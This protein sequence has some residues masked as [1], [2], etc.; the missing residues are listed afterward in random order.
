MSRIIGNRGG[1]WRATVTEHGT[2]VPE[3][4]S[5]ELA[6]HVAGD[7]R[8]Y[9]PTQ[10]PTLRQKWYAGFPVCETRLRVGNGDIVQRIYSVADL[11][12]MTVIE[13][14]N[15]STLPV[16]IAVTR[17]DVFTMRAPADNPPAGIDLPASSIVLPLGHKSTTRIALAHKNPASGRLPED[18]PDHQQ[19]V[20]GWEAACDVA[21]R[22]T[23]P[24]HTVVAG[25]ARVRSDLLLGVGVTEDAS[26]ELVRLAETHRDSIVDVVET[27]QRRVKAEKRAKVL[28]WDTPHLLASAARACVLLGDEVAAG[29]IGSTWLRLAD[30]D[31]QDL[32]VEI[33]SGLGAIAWAESLLAQASPSGGKCTVLPHG[34][35]ETWWGSAFEGH[36]LIADPYRTISF[37]VRWHG[38]RPA[39][40]WEV[41]GA[42]GLLIT[43]GKADSEWHTTEV[44]GE[45]L[46]AAP[47]SVNV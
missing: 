36:G 3:D 29:D 27:V 21:S 40:L 35:P 38:P 6:W 13:F 20:R 44:S 47:I 10:E 34:I 25:I 11:G 22:I 41:T 42:P 26:I 19:V 5:A 43:A 30:R 31:V 37:A 33:P 45:A 14:E 9:T 12:G 39:V 46:L 17:N 24:D 23:M 4:G 16:A 15:E 7:D 32:P 18:T 8:W 28:Q 1:S 2:V